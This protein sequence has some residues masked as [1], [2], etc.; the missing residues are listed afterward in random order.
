MSDTRA[1]AL[2]EYM[3]VFDGVISAEAIDCEGGFEAGWDACQSRLT[4]AEKCLADIE[5]KCKE[6][7][8]EVNV[9]S[10]GILKLISEYRKNK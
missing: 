10:P 5:A 7:F 8:S 4:N 1:K 6:R 3:S 9:F 2:S